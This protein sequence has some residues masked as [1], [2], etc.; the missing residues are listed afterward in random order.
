MIEVIFSSLNFVEHIVSAVTLE[1]K[2]STHENIQKDSERPS[3]DFTVV[4]SVQNFWCHIIRST[5]NSLQLLVSFLSLGK[6]EINQLE[7][8][9]SRKH[10]VLWLNI[11]MHNS[12]AVHV[13]ASAKHFLHVLFCLF[14]TKHLIFLRSNL[15][16]QFS[17][18]NILHDQINIL[19]IHVSLVILYDVGVVESGEDLHFFLNGVEVIL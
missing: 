13:M 17:T 5:G 2:V 14:F 9:T 4:L 3:I 7:F 1:G 6:T 10:D 16:E 15:V 19:F 8:A 11:S 12:L 18:T